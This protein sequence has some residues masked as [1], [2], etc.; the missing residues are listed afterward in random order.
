M[1]SQWI[2]DILSLWWQLLFNNEKWLTLRSKTYICKWFSGREV[3]ICNISP[4]EWIGKKDLCHFFGNDL[5]LLPVTKLQLTS[6]WS[7]V[8]L[9]G[10]CNNKILY[11]FHIFLSY[12]CK[13]SSVINTTVPFAKSKQKRKPPIS[14]MNYSILW[15][16]SPASKSGYLLLVLVFCRDGKESSKSR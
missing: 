15:A 13:P 2:T 6:A 10:I 14:W 11:G 7:K 16:G 3:R 1:L 12:K 5:V 9:Y 4:T 8:G